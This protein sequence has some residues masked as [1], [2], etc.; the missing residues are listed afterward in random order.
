MTWRNLG[1]ALPSELSRDVAG[2]PHVTTTAGKRIL[3]RG[4]RAWWGIAGVWEYIR[5][6]KN[7]NAYGRQDET[8][9][10]AGVKNKGTMEP[11][12]LLGPMGL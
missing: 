5:V 7:L 10:E 3:T 6:R 8:R 11:C 2:E 9:R 1:V 12:A 4:L